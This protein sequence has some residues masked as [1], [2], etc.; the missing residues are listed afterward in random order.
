MPVDPLA[1]E[2]E[3]LE[4]ELA[5]TRKTLGTLISWMTQALNSPLRKD[6]AEELLRMLEGKK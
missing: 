5:R 1:A 4:R 6:E 3:K 2:V